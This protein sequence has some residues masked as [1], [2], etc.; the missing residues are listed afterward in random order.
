[1]AR[2]LGKEL[3][4]GFEIDHINRD[5]LDNRRAN[6]RVVTHAANCLNR[7]RSGPPSTSGT[8][9]VTWLQLREV[10]VARISVNGERVLLGAFKNIEDAIIARKVA[11]ARYCGEAQ[12]KGQARA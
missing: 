9:G 2:M 8:K 10:W 5:S 7:H 11:E 1:M 3:E 6:L 12:D 4:P